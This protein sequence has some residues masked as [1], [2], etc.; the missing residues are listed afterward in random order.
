MQVLWPVI[1]AFRWTFLRVMPAM[2][3]TNRAFIKAYRQD[4]ADESPAGRNSPAMLNQ[5]AASSREPAA[6]NVAKSTAVTPPTRST[7]DPQRVEPKQP[8]TT[9]IYH[10]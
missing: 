7:F 8:H 4:T 5:N 6:N 10:T 9:F 2:S 1:R 3:T